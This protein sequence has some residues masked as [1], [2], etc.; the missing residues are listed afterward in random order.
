MNTYESITNFLNT[1]SIHLNYKAPKNNLEK[2]LYNLAVTRFLEQHENQY[3]LANNVIQ[4]FFDGK[5][6]ICHSEY[7]ETLKSMGLKSTI[8]PFDITMEDIKFDESVLKK[9]ISLS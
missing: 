6:F 9:W 7:E 3:Y 2:I 8:F 1:K 5:L 4:V